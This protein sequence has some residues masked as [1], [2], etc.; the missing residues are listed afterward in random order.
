MEWIL[1]I[2]FYICLL[3]FD[4][5]NK[6]LIPLILICFMAL[7]IIS[8]NSCVK[9]VGPLPKISS[10]PVQTFCDS[11]NVKWSTD[12]QPIINTNC[13]NPGCHAAG[14]GSTGVDLSS[15]SFID[16]A[17]IR[18]RVLDGNPTYMPRPPIT[19]PLPLLDRQKIECWLKA[20]APNN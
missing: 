7:I 16:T 17:R 18:A 14:G 1:S 5:M 19:S 9:D 15:Y 10:A 12:I 8:Y 13:V 2:N 11:L 4:N 3:I 6:R 20:G